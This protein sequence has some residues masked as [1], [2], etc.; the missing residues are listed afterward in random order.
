LSSSDASLQ[1]ICA[2]SDTSSRARS[3]WPGVLGERFRWRED[4]VSILA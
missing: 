1:P 2:S 4:W 3:S